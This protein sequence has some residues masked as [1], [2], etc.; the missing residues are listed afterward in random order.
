MAGSR[1]HIPRSRNCCPRDNAIVLCRGHMLTSALIWSYRISVLVREANE[2]AY[3]CVGN[4]SEDLK[5]SQ[6]VTMIVHSCKLRSNCSREV[7]KHRKTMEN[8]GSFAGLCSCHKCRARLIKC[9]WHVVYLPTN[10][11]LL[12]LVRPPV[13]KSR[14]SWVGFVFKSLHHWGFRLMLHASC[15]AYPCSAAQTLPPA[16]EQAMHL[17]NRWA[18]GGC[19]TW[20]VCS[21]TRNGV[22]RLA[23]S[24]V[25]NLYNPP[26]TLRS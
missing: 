9:P 15:Y 8:Y 26:G 14:Q 16:S 21:N 3:K 24:L 22:F 23:R 20:Q 25:P 5:S 10:L 18:T 13:K 4:T 7:G 19:P 12:D 1:R 11:S 17:P 2:K 6:S